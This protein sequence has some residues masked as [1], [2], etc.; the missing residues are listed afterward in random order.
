M[1]KIIETKRLIIRKAE[2]TEKDIDLYFQLWNHPDVMK[3]VGFPKGLHFLKERISEQLSKQPNS[4]FDELLLV[5]IK[6]NG[7]LIGEA[8][9]GFPDNEGISKTDIKL[10]PEFWGNGFGK[11]IKQCLIDYIFEKTD[12]I[13]VEGSPNKKNIASIKMQEFV[14]A[15]KIKEGVYHF[16]ESMKGFTEDVHCVI[17]HVFRK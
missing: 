15:K 16:P 5:E 9:L 3:F 12:A 2:N 13:A 14:G 8:K 7:V 11:E 10:L 6:E 1:K 17:Y 4:E